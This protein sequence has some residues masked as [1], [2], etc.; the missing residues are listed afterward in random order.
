MEELNLTTPKVYEDAYFVDWEKKRERIENM[1]HDFQNALI[2]IGFDPRGKDLLEV[3]TFLAN[4]LNTTMCELY[5]LKVEMYNK[6][7]KIE[8]KIN[9]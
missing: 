8:E 7:Y 1:Q 4:E 3:I 2:S 9:Q 5:Q 6:I